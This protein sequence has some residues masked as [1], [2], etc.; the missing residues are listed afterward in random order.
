MKRLL[1]GTLMLMTCLCQIFALDVT[2]QPGDD[3]QAAIDRVSAANT[4]GKV[5][6]GEGVYE[7]TETLVLKNYVTIVGAGRDKT[8]LRFAAGD[9]TALQNKGEY[10]VLKDAGVENL[11]MEGET[12]GTERYAVSITALGDTQH[13]N[14]TF[15]DVEITNLG[16]SH[17]KRCTNLVVKNC[18]FHDNFFSPDEGGSLYFQ[19]LYIRYCEGVTLQDCDLSGN[20]SSSCLH[21]VGGTGITLSHVTGN[22]SLV[23]DGV[24]IQENPSEMVIENCTFCD[25]YRVGLDVQAGNGITIT[26]CTCTG[27][28]KN[29]SCSGTY[30]MSDNNIFVDDS[31]GWQLNVL[32]DGEYYIQ[33][34][35]NTNLYMTN[36]NVNGSGGYPSFTAK[37]IVQSQLNTQIWIVEKDGPNYKITS[38]ADNRS[39]KETAGYVISSYNAPWNT[40]RIYTAPDGRQAIQQDQNALGNS[41]DAYFWGISGSQLKQTSN[42]VADDDQLQ[43][44]FVPV[45]GSTGINDHTLTSAVSKYGYNLMGNRVFVPCTNSII[46]TNGKKYLWK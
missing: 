18:Y 9:F 20:P 19:N 21:F 28:G 4:K 26:N 12:K 38:K 5:I 31:L 2:V 39:L 11:R 40:Y 13:R 14:I 44:R 45:N 7:C 29:Y 36:S 37:R 34:T 33:K 8:T 32:E 43:F 30:S 46:I 35:A 41:G 15:C 25:N 27:N 42:T 17:F 22:N 1:L 6:L 10:S 3:I 24:N 16:M 23:Q